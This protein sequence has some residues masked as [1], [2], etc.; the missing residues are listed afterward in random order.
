MV[1]PK[2]RILLIEDST[3]S[4]FWAKKALEEKGYYVD[5]AA[6]GR[7]AL[8]RIKG[9]DKVYDLIISDIHLPDY[10]GLDLIES[11][12]KDRR[13]L[14][15]PIM[16]LTVDNKLPVIKRAIELGAVEYMCKPFSMDELIKRVAKII[17]MP[18]SGGYKLL[19]LEDILRKEIKRAERGSLKLSV[20]Y[21]SKRKDNDGREED[22]EAVLKNNLREIDSVIAVSEKEVFVI[23]P[24]TG[25]DGAE[26]V[27]NKLKTLL[28]EEWN[29]L[30][31]SYPED[32][33]NE[34]DLLH[35]LIK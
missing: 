18:E 27:V 7:E 10:N 9:N 29:F 5:E 15:V 21:I 31:L 6:T 28:K 22:I 2:K 26:V 4:R 13:Y 19:L 23:L 24:L 33:H 14:Y 11:I 16:I 20:I 32:G 30:V 17:G 3:L 12:K 25:R 34:K 8:T 1:D 35:N